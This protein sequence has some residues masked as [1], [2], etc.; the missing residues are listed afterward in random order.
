MSVSRAEE[1][2]P[3]WIVHISA[4][5]IHQRCQQEV[6]S[7]LNR[8]HNNQGDP[9]HQFGFASHKAIFS[10]VVFPSAMQVYS[11]SIDVLTSGPIGRRARNRKACE[12]FCT[13]NTSKPALFNRAPKVSGLTGTRVSPI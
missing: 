11:F 9:G 12:F 8:R 4:V 3:Q 5:P 6:A 2:L 1:I 13:S 10:L 7:I